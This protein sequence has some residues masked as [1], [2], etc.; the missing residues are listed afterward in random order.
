MKCSKCGTESVA[1]IFKC[2]DCSEKEA[3][4]MSK[5]LKEESNWFKKHTANYAR[6]VQVC[7]ELESQLL[8]GRFKGDG[9]LHVQDLGAFKTFLESLKICD[10]RTL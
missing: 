3:D 1:G 2:L 10:P 5:I 9:D 4:K 6:L 7:R 8:M